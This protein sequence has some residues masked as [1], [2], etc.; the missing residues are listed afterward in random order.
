MSS[1][2]ELL[3]QIEELKKK[4]KDMEKQHKDTELNK[5]R[6]FLINKVRDFIGIQVSDAEVLA[7]LAKFYSNDHRK[8]RQDFQYVPI[9]YYIKEEDQNI[10]FERKVLNRYANSHTIRYEDSVDIIGDFLGKI[11]PINPTPEMLGQIIRN[12]QGNFGYV[13]LFC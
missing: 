4:A 8:S 7:I 11:K 9:K 13:P 5:Q 1:E 3:D 6:K 2:K 10:L 12:G